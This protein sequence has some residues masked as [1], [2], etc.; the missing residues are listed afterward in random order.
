MEKKAWSQVF[1]R[2][3]INNGTFPGTKRYRNLGGVK[4]N[5]TMGDREEVNSD[6]N[7]AEEAE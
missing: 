7:T 4:L 6:R 1:S 2:H 5:D 3:R